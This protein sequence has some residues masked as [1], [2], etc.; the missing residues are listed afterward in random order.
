METTLVDTAGM[1]VAVVLTLFVF[2]YLLSDNV[3]FRLAEHLFVGLSIGY[4]AVVVFHSILSA[5]LIVPMIGALGQDNQG[6]RVLLL[7]IPLVLGLLL[8]TRPSKRFSWLGGLS[9]AFLMGVGSALAI[10][11]SL[12]GTLLPQADATAD[13]VGDGSALGLLGGLVVLTGTTGVLL[14]FHFEVGRDGRLA[15][16]RDRIVRIWGGLGRWFVV[17]AFGAILATTFMSRLSLLVG[18]IEFLLDSMR[19]LFG[20]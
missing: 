6:E 11:G 10:G 14:H 8:L 9:V 17:I 3:L 20:G 15:G 1:W 4:A 19:G 18:R 12:L 5:K 2:S 7:L 16:F 13:I